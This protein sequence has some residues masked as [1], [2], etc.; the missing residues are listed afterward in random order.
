MLLQPSRLSDIPGGLGIRGAPVPG[1]PA[2]DTGGCGG[3]SS[4]AHVLGIFHVLLSAALGLELL[5][6]EAS[7]VLLPERPEVLPDV[8]GG[9]RE[10][11]GSYCSGS[12]DERADDRDWVLRVVVPNVGE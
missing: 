3:S 4:T 5:K 10:V 7:A 12:P 2:G 8:E 1:H 11:D 6:S 9:T